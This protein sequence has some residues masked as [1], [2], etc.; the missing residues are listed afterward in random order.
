MEILR[1]FS[2][3]DV[4]TWK[5]YIVDTVQFHTFEG[6]MLSFFITTSAMWLTKVATTC[7]NISRGYLWKSS[8]IELWYQ[9]MIFFGWYHCLQHSFFMESQAKPQLRSHCV[10]CMW[11]LKQ[12]S[13]V[14]SALFLGL[15]CS[16]SSVLPRWRR[17]LMNMKSMILRS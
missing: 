2:M 7:Y 8:D 6:C 1:R 3:D 11:M 14:M 4:L 10:W 12:V 13:V 5:K 9:S 16:L 15:M 17:M